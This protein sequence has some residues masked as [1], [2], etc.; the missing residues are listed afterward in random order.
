MHL[1]L[2]SVEQAKKLKELGFDWSVDRYYGGRYPAP[3]VALALKWFRDEK[4]LLNSINISGQDVDNYN[5]WYEYL[6]PNSYERSTAFLYYEEA[7]SALL[8]ALIEYAE[9]KEWDM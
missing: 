4:D 2:V 3:F 9:G 8:D 1:Q 5:I 7:E 6:T